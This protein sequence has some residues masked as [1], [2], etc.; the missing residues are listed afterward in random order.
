MASSIAAVAITASSRAAGVQRLAPQ[1]PLLPEAFAKASAR[2]RSSVPTLMPI[3]ADSVATGQLCGGSNRATALSFVHTSHVSRP[4]T[5]RFR[6]YPGGNFSDTGGMQPAPLMSV[7]NWCASPRE[8]AG[9]YQR[10]MVIRS[11]SCTSFTLIC[12]VSLYY[13]A[14]RAD[15]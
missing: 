12:S 11:K 4:S 10:P 2:Q 13:G 7:T 5:L 14:D 3:L 1:P 9:L 8:Y 15:Q 6:S